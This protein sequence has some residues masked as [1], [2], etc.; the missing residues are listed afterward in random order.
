MSRVSRSVLVPIAALCAALV[1][2]IAA[3]APTAAPAGRW[4]EA[5]AT[6][7]YRAQPWLVGANYTPANAINQLEMWQADTFDPARIDRELGWAAAIGM[8]TMRVFL[9]DLRLAA[10]R[11]R[12]QEPYRA[13]PGHCRQAPHQADVRAVRLGVGSA[14]EAGQAA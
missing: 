4:S 2:P 3:Q 12:L 7:W 5:K 13:V 6:E 8:N 1:Q 9:H 14:A 10:G 11:G